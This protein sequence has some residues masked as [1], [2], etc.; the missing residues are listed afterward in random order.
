MVANREFSIPLQDR[1]ESQHIQEKG[2]A[3]WHITS[4]YRLTSRLESP[5]GSVGKATPAIEY[6]LET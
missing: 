4:A 3:A 2:T 6:W 5:T 1:I